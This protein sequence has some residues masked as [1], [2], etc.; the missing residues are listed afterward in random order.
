[1]SWRIIAGRFHLTTLKAKGHSLFVVITSPAETTLQN[2]P[3][4][5]VST[6]VILNLVTRRPGGGQSQASRHGGKVLMLNCDHDRLA[7]PEVWTW[8]S[9]Q[10]W[11]NLHRN[12][13]NC[14]RYNLAC[15]WAVERNYRL[16]KGIRIWW[17]LA[18]VA[19]LLQP[20]RFI[21]A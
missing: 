15:F 12:V 6:A 3:P 7:Q 8:L 16:A 13:Q 14:V 2:V 21:T 20:V 17:Q 1:M 10:R 4:K 5:L 18:P 9:N 11:D 19:C